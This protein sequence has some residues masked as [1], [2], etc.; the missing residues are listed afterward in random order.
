MSRLIPTDF[1]TEI[2]RAYSDLNKKPARHLAG[3]CHHAFN[4]L[5]LISRN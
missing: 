1:N 3:F 5:A 2:F 4:N